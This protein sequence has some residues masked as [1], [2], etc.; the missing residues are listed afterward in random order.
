MASRNVMNT[1][2]LARR[3]VETNPAREMRH[4]LGTSP[5]R[6][7]LMPGDHSAMVRGFTEELIVPKTNRAAEQLRRGH[8]NRRVPEQ[9]MK[10]R[11]DTPG[12]QRMKQNG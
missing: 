8:Q 2:V 5:V 1:T 12:S 11:R 4:G 10:S 3:I 9:I 7:I 6:I